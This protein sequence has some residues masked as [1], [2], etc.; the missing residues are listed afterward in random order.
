MLI[1]SSIE[2][3]SLLSDLIKIKPEKEM[4]DQAVVELHQLYPFDLKNRWLSVIDV[5]RR[6]VD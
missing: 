6:F 2:Q 5:G 4:S 1:P 3:D